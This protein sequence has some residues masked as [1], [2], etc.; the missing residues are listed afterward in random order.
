MNAAPQNFDTDSILKRLAFAYTKST[1]ERLA[2]MAKALGSINAENI[3]GDVVECGVWRGGN[4]V[5]ARLM[6]PERVCWLYDT[7]AG[8]TEPTE[9]DVSR[10]KRRAIDLYKK[11]VIGTGKWTAVPLDEVKKS[12]VD[13][14]VYDETK[15]RFVVGPVEKTLIDESNLPDKIALLRLDTDW[16]ESTK[17]ELEVLWPRLV[18]G[19]VLIVDD[20][21]HWMGAKKAVDDFFVDGLPSFERVDYSAI[22]LLKT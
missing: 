11:K 6:S 21:G 13:F 2:S 9:W 12:F 15:L 5:L 4:I 3:G 20:Y 8:M 18:V 1:P 16:Y 7:F 22:M 19:G 10:G 14:D 17:V